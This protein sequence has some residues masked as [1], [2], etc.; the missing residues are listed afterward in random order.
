MEGVRCNLCDKICGSKR[1]LNSHIKA[2]HE[3]LKNKIDY[4]CE[5]C[6]KKFCKKQSLT[7]HEE[8]IHLKLDSEIRCEYCQKTLLSKDGLKDHVKSFHLDENDFHCDQC[9]KSYSNKYRLNRHVTL[10]HQPYPE[11]LM[12]K[13]DICNMIIKKNSLWSHLQNH[14]EKTRSA[15]N[16]ENYELLLNDSVVTDVQIPNQCKICHKV[17]THLQLHIKTLH[18]QCKKY[19]NKLSMKALVEKDILMK[20]QEK[21]MRKALHFFYVHLSFFIL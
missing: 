11:K 6:E 14:T 13:C 7:S 9:D 19:S 20:K 16:V 3:S 4:E 2:K 5:K 18:K 8:K 15:K 21:E 17:V 10:L 1:I 12:T